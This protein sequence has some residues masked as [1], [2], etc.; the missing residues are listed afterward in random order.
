MSMILKGHSEAI[1]YSGG[2]FTGTCDTTKYSSVFLFME[3]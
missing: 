1:E 2:L 3:D